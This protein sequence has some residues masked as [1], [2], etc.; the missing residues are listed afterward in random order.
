MNRRQA[1]TGLWASLLACFAGKATAAAHAA[2]ATTAQRSGN[3]SQPGSSRVH[4]LIRDPV[5][6]SSTWVYRYDRAGRLLSVKQGANGTP[7]F[8]YTYSSQ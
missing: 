7:S 3:L 2:V 1:L 4:E 6:A 5:D 8:Q